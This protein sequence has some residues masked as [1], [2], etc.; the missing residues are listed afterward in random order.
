MKLKPGKI[1]YVQSFALP[2]DEYV[3]VKLINRVLKPDD[4]WGADGWD[5]QLIYKK[6]VD[7]LIKHGVPY[8]RNEKPAVWVFDFQI[9]K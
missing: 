2:D 5:A 3:R 1:I 8:K 4:F 6:D 9:K 7:K